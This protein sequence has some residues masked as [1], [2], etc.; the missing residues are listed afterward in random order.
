MNSNQLYNKFIELVR[1]SVNGNAPVP[2][3][4]TSDEWRGVFELAA[5]H[6]M[7]GICSKGIERLP[8]EERPP[9]DVSRKWVFS[10]LEIERRNRIMNKRCVQLTR[11]LEKDG[12]PPCILKGQGAA[13]LYPEPLLRQSGDIDVWVKGGHRRLVRYVRS[14]FPETPAR[15]H[16]IDFPVFNDIPVEIHFMPSWMNNPSDNRKLQK[17]FRANEEAA[18]RNY[19]SLPE[20]AGAV[21]VPTAE[22]NIVYMLIHIYHH[23]FDEGIGLRQLTD[24]Y[25]L[26]DR[27]FHCIDQ[28]GRKN[29]T[30]TLKS[31]GLLPF[32]G[33]LMYVLHEIFLLD[34]Q[35]MITEMSAED[36]SQKLLRQILESGNFG[37]S[38]KSIDRTKGKSVAYFL[39]KFRYKAHFIREYPKETFWNIWFWIWQRVWR[40]RHG[41]V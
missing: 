26:L 17:W 21:I 5:R 3:R 11:M 31:I 20:D 22:F 34:R 15:Y 27:H 12:L 25:F 23:L 16:H 10:T 41:Y 40:A 39:T 38:N 9:A 30:D 18:F 35:K 24:Y 32:A 4:M 33:N 36:S 29:I 19:V 13:L 28:C 14:R 8:A 2:A 37:C 7:L 6:A 1:L